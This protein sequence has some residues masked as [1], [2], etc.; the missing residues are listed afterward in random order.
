M[1]WWSIIGLKTLSNKR[2]IRYGG[3]IALHLKQ[4]S[5]MD[6]RRI[7][8]GSCKYLYISFSLSSLQEQVRAM[9][10][11]VSGS[12]SSTARWGMRRCSDSVDPS[13]T[14][15]KQLSQVVAHVFTWLIPSSCELLLE[16]LS[17]FWI[18]GG[19][20]TSFFFS[21]KLQNKTN[22]VGS[23]PNYTF[24]SIM[25]LQLK[26][27]NCWKELDLSTSFHHKNWENPH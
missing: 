7:F 6:E 17:V 20:A 23:F 14:F 26:A 11:A 16:F 12:S 2:R 19:K 10:A 24:H 21:G 22:I 9:Q 13:N 1:K 25:A 18:V 4:G 8:K 5:Q 27:L 15:W 3:S